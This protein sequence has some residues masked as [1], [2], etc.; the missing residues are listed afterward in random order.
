[1]LD[2]NNEEGAADK[3]E[4]QNV[5]PG[6]RREK[7]THIVKQIAH[8]PVLSCPFRNDGCQC[9]VSRDARSIV[10]MRQPTS[11]VGGVTSRWR[12]SDRSNGCG[13]SCV[14]IS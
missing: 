6:G 4:C 1:M 12:K 11:C 5:F 10:E 8:F 7:E 13:V 2:M 14:V 3:D 9:H